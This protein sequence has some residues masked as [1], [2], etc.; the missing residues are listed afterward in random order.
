M[1]EEY[2]LEVTHKAFLLRPDT[3]EEGAPRPLRPGERPGELSLHLKEVALDAGLD[4]MRRPERTSNSM[5]ALQTAKHAE[6]H[7]ALERV[8]DGF[9]R[10]YWEEGEDI[11]AL[12]VV[13]RVAEEAGLAWAPL[14][15]ALETSAYVGEVLRDYELAQAVGFT[16]VPA[17][18]FGAAGFTGAQPIGVFRRAAEQAA[19]ALRADPR[20]FDRQREAFAARPESG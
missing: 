3:P 12:T 13:R 4:K 6:R 11:G 10:A 14:E 16:A 19:E 2:P 9:Y 7:G 5:R 15:A 8:V 17:F 1:G 18:V 20:A